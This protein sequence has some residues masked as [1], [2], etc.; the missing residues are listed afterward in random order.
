MKK[1]K[2]QVSIVRLENQ[3]GELEVGSLF[4]EK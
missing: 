2:K 1:E 3:S 4:F